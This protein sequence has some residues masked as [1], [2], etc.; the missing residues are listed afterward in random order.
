MIA[1]GLLLL[2]SFGGLGKGYLHIRPQQFLVSHAG[3]ALDDINALGKLPMAV[4]KR[5]V[6]SRCAGGVLFCARS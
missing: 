3:A 4:Q 1:L 2:T 5:F 6:V